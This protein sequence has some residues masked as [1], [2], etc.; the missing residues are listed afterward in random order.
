[1]HGC[2]SILNGKTFSCQKYENAHKK[3]ISMLSLIKS[4]KIFFS[5][6]II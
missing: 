3:V 5:Q 2:A 1:M 4:H 6:H